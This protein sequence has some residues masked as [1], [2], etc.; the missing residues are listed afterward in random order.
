MRETFFEWSMRGIHRPDQFVH[1]LGH[2]LELAT[3]SLSNYYCF[4][5]NLYRVQLIL[6]GGRVS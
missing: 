1:S 5:D 2:N 3:F 4:G 6:I